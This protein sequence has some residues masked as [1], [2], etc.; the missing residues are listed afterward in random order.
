MPVASIKTLDFS[1]VALI[2]VLACGGPS[3]SHMAMPTVPRSATFERASSGSWDGAM[4]QLASELADVPRD[5][6]ALRVAVFDFTDAAGNDRGLG[7]T[8]AGEP[9][10]LSEKT[11]ARVR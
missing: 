1:T 2:C 7:S 5:R 3:A 8:I 4:A 10:V 11:T 9:S 6:G